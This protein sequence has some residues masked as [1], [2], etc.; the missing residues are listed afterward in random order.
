MKIPASPPLSP[1]I[2]KALIV[3]SIN[4]KV[5][6]LVSGEATIEES[7]VE[8]SNINDHSCLLWCEVLPDSLVTQGIEVTQTGLQESA[9]RLVTT[10]V[11][12]IEQTNAIK[13]VNGH[14]P[15]IHPLP[16][17]LGNLVIDP[18]CPLKVGSSD[19]D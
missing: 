12:L 1:G 4:D 2:A 16:H 18:H 17:G 8:S 11:G 15:S 5:L 19:N 7:D 9:T 6:V 13:C 3:V 14:D 10:D